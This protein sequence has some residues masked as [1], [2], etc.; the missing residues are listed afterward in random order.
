MRGLR[1]YTVSGLVCLGVLLLAGYARAEEPQ[2]A[3]PPTED[4]LIAALQADSPWEAKEA[5]CRALR[6]VGTEKAVPALAA[7]LGDPK[8]GHL[9]RYALEPMK[10]EAAG[11]ALREALQRVDGPARVGIAISLGARRDADAIPL[12]APLLDVEDTALV[13]AAAGAL[14]RIG[15]PEAAAI[16]LTAAQK[17][18]SAVRVDV[19]EGLLAAAQALTDVGQGSVALTYDE[20]LLDGD[21][22]AQVRTGAFAGAAYADK[23]GMPGRLLAALGGDDPVFRD[24]AAQIVAETQGAAVTQMYVDAL[25]GL[26]PAGQVALLH[27]L[28]GRKDPVARPGAVALL[29]SKDTAVQVAAL[30]AMATLGSAENVPALA[31][32]LGTTN[33]APLRAAQASLRGM[34]DPGVDQALADLVKGA[35]PEVRAQLLDLMTDRL[36]AQTLPAAIANL[37]DGD[38]R[39]RLAALRALV[40]L[41]TL[42]QGTLTLAA[43]RTAASDSE[44]NL[45]AKALGNIAKQAQDDAL[46]LLLNAMASAKP[47]VL[48]VLIRTLDRVG[49]THA[50]NA[51]VA[52]VKGQDPASREEA[53]KVLSAWRSPEA[54]PHLL[55]M[56]H[57]EDAA[58]HDLGL[59]GYVRLARDE[60]APETQAVMLRQAMEM[61][62]DKREKWL[63]LA[64]WGTVRSGTALEALLPHLEDAEVRN[65]AAAAI[66]TVAAEL[67]KQDALRPAAKDALNTV[68]A[69]C[70]DPGI[71]SRAE[72]ALAKIA[73]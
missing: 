18:S 57:S 4:E 63:V 54:T 52:L 36:A 50:L 71:R 72:G 58:M 40:E 41:G 15:T 9:A 56:A 33:E 2:G 3:L 35:A 29:E 28:A 22:P 60:T 25:P 66:I 73:G 39:V 55:E 16:L 23:S 67:A 12:L 51:V 48:P 65:E 32:F 46:P 64:A 20:A 37:G 49:T 34:D 5:A 14:G 11:A 44:R 53:A 45:A 30:E 6:Q 26:P 24:M 42:E 1:K 10:S 62:R 31:T 17:A 61:S 69:K 8:T 68:L 27:G 70:D 38:E 7:L 43:L 59:R 47:E 13:R 19:A 21:W